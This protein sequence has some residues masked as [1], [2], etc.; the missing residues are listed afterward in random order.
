MPMHVKVQC[1]NPKCGR[2]YRVHRKQ[3]GK[4]ASCSHCGQKFA[5]TAPPLETTDDVPVEEAS[6]PET[7]ASLARIGRFEVRKRIGAGA[8]G[9]VY[10]AFD[11]TLGREVAL[12][13]P[14]AAA[15][16]RPE[17]RARFLREPK[18]AAQLR[19]PHIVP[20][21]DA[22]VD[23]ERYYIASAFIEGRTLDDVIA[24]KRLGYRQ[25]AEVVVALAD[26][27]DYAHSHGVVHRDVKPANVMLDHQGQPM[28]VDFGLARLESS[29]EKLTH[30]GSLMGTPAYMAPEQVDASFGTVGPAS[31]QYALGVVLYQLLTG[32][33]PFSGPP[34]A[35]IYSIVNQDPP[36]PRF[37][38]PEAPPDLETICLKAM[39]KQPG[40][41]YADCGTLAE[42]LRRWLDSKPIRARRVGPAERLRMWSRRNPAAFVSATAALLL[43]IMAVLMTAGLLLRG[44]NPNADAVG[45][46]S[47]A[48]V[49][50]GHL[51]SI[52]ESPAAG[53]LGA[54]QTTLPVDGVGLADSS[55]GKPLPS[56]DPAGPA[57][58]PHRKAPPKLNETLTNS[59][60]ME[61]KLI[62]AGEFLMGSPE[63]ETQ[64]F[65]GETPQH[66][67]QIAKPFYLGLHEVT[68][69]QY[70]VVMDE[71]PKVSGRPSIQEVREMHY[72]DVMGSTPLPM[73]GPTLPVWG[74]PWKD[75]LEFCNRLSEREGREYRLPTEAEW[76]Y[77]CR[78][79]TTT[80]WYFGEQELELNEC[81]WLN[82]NSQGA[83]HPV[84][85]KR[86]NPWGLY[87]MYGNVEEWCSDWYDEAYYGESPIVDPKG[88]ETK[89]QAGHVLRSG[90]WHMDMMYARSAYR[91]FQGSGTWLPLVGFRVAISP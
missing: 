21:Y 49:N 25:T 66:R 40:G 16:E 82:S 36:G 5:V 1:P 7:I 54:N 59:I 9:T 29:D 42:D 44:S 45:V 57:S 51:T 43:L 12:K 17:V 35:Q 63:Y 27:L 64:R 89:K 31:D 81:A 53:K 80:V 13:V 90:S 33:T 73:E 60:G 79:G 46:E 83:P 11:P 3:L 26:A 8:F 75:A 22:G 86:P 91:G 14:R 41:R 50:D 23:G 70:Q 52:S 78:A 19:H 58:P 48:P 37:V 38:N 65:R 34:T 61:F 10:R 88:P 84:G 15:M 6:R 32:T 68:Q 76:E 4:N 69:E 77:A 28:L 85:Q 18:A 47:V 39:S 24:E 30:D 20:V 2:T 87:D 67:V 71:I 72:K 62:P 56:P 55:G 74:V